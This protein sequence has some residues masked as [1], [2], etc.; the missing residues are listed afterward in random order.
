MNY[1]DL[2]KRL[3]ACGSSDPGAEAAALSGMPRA[4]C[5]CN[6][7]APLPES[8]EARLLRRESGEPLQYIL[9]EAWFYG[10]PFKVSPACL[11]PQPDTEIAVD[12]ALRRISDGM[13]ILDLCTGSGCIAISI[14]KENA[15]LTADALD[16]SADA[17][18]IAQENAR[19]LGV[20]EHIR[21]HRADVF[22]DPICDALAAAADLIIS[23]PPYINTAV[24]PTL[25]EE[26]RR[27]PH[28]ALDG[29]ADGMDFYRHFIRH[30][31]PRMKPHARMILEIGYDQGE[32]MEALCR[33]AG[34]ACTL[35]RDFGGNIRV[36][37]IARVAEITRGE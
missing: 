20:G 9:G 36:A 25:S 19:L 37:E 14:L 1:I 31:A 30:L 12:L 33:E 28:I 10:Y 15:S 32:R 13:R 35:H 2:R 21:F 23:N 34:L 3:I 8:A 18:E 4:W 27:E 16:I 17:L 29:G 22:R 5:L 6:Q 24:I 7:T 26:V 11:I